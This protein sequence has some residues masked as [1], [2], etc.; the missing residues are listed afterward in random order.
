LDHS[1]RQLEIPGKVK[2]KRRSGNSALAP[3]GVTPKR[4][5]YTHSTLP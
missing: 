3:C 4:S 2:A 5:L 1:P